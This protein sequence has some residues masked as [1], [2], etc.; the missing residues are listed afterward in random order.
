MF[1]FYQ[2]PG[3]DH[4]EDE[5]QQG[6]VLLNGACA[7]LNNPSSQDNQVSSVREDNRNTDSSYITNLAEHSTSLPDSSSNEVITSGRKH[8]LDSTCTGIPLVS[9]LIQNR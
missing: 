9:A 1:S 7:P 2:D 5:L 3:Q 6:D 8:I 4:F